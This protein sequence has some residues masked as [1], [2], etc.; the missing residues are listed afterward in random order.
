MS[1]HTH[2]DLPFMSRASESV[3]S[4][5]VFRRYRALDRAYLCVYMLQLSLPVV[6]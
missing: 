3:V 5:H 1:H 2:L 4:S 6:T